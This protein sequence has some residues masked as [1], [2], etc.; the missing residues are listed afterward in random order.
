[1]SANLGRNAFGWSRNTKRITVHV[2]Y[3]LRVILNVSQCQ[4]AGRV[5]TNDNKNCHTRGHGIQMVIRAR[6]LLIF[7]FSD[8]KAPVQIT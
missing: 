8:E 3:K 2:A 1:M 5:Y 7:F 4:P 6:A